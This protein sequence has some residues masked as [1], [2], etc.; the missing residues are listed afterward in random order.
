MVDF[1]RMVWQEC[2]QII[3][4]VA[5]LNEAGKSK[6]EQYWP[7]SQFVCERYGPFSIS[8][9][10]EQVLPDIVI[11]NMRVWVRAHMHLLNNT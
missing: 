5:N 1:W 4:M 6:C 2:S 7:T 11:R 10:G 3:V 8:L 9:M